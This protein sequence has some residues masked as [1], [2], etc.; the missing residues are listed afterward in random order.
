MHRSRPPPHA[1]VT[2]AVSP[3]SSA[4]VRSVP[5]ASERSGVDALPD[6]CAARQPMERE[7]QKQ[8]AS[9]GAV[10]MPLELRGVQPLGSS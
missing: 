5:L 3:S 8:T 4:E 9:H 6:R 7:G 2:G 10:A 1:P